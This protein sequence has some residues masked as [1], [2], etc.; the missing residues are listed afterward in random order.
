MSQDLSPE[1]IE[2]IK[3]KLYNNNTIPLFS[4]SNKGFLTDENA[5][6]L[7]VIIM[8]VFVIGIV[9]VPSDINT[10]G[11]WFHKKEIKNKNNF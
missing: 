7:I 10:I 5:N 6:L 4:K 9:L 2:E 11:M 3:W 1:E 8:T